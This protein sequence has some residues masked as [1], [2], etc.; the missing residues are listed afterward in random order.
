MACRAIALRYKFDRKANEPLAMSELQKALSE[1]S[2]IRGH[3]ARGAEF[4][5]YGPSTLAATGLLARR[6][7]AV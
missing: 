3:L 4:R 5:G 6:W 2:A 1:I 7:R